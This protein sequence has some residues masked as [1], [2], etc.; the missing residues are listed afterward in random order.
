MCHC[1]VF[2]VTFT[3]TDFIVVFYNMKSIECL[4]SLFSLKN[5]F[6]ITFKV[7]L[8]AMINFFLLLLLFTWK[9][10]YFDIIFQW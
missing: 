7:I 2:I 3:C 8:L 9:Y 10:L 6:N 5:Y 4:V 1:T